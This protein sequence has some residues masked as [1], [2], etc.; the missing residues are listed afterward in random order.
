[1]PYLL[2]S[3]NPSRGRT[4]AAIAVSAT[5][6]SSQV[7]SRL[8]LGYHWLSDTLASLCLS[9]VVLGLVIAVD[10]WRTVRTPGEK[11]TGDLSK[12]QSERT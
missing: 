5:V 10:T 6:I 7:L 11:V 3:R 1:M 4:A 9:M 12:V 2:L 8:Y